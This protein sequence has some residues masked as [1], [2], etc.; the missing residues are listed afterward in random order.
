MWIEEQW[1]CQVPEGSSPII[2]FYYLSLNAQPLIDD[3]HYPRAFF[4]R[5]IGYHL[6]EGD[7][8]KGREHFNPWTTRHALGREHT[9]SRMVIAGPWSDNDIPDGLLAKRIW[10]GAR[11]A[12][13]HDIND[14]IICW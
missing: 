6:N 14:S 1:N 3:H 5:C 13:A 10:I 7:P 2:S 9:R 8:S 11:H 4:H 12:C